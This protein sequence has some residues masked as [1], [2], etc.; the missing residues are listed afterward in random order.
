MSTIVVRK[1]KREQR[2][3]RVRAHVQGTAL[4]PR[5]YVFKSNQHIY[6]GAVDD[7]KGSTLVSA[8]DISLKAAGTHNADVARLIG[9]SVGKALRKKGVKKIVFDRGGYRYHGKV[10]AVAEGAR[11]AGLIF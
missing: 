8:S 1:K 4:R 10:K 3:K 9:E 11:L 6:C 7:E 2:R 5:L